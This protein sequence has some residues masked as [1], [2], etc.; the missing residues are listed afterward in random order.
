MDGVFG[1]GKPYTVGIEEEFQLV[2]PGSRGLVPAVERVIAAGNGT[3]LVTSELSRSCVE[4]VSPVYET[5]SDLA[6]ELPGLRREVAEMAR[7]GGAEIVAAGT[8]PFSEP[9]EQP[10]AIQVRAERVARAA[11]AIPDWPTRQRRGDSP[12]HTWAPSAPAATVSQAI[13][14]PV[15]QAQA[16]Q[17]ARAAEA[18]PDW[19]TRQRRSS[20]VSGNQ[21]G[22][23]GEIVRAGMT[24]SQTVQPPRNQKG[25]IKSTPPKTHDQRRPNCQRIRNPAEYRDTTGCPPRNG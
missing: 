1:A 6:R 4:M 7:K 10:L 13:Q 9:T 15:V 25:Y 22:T 19:P 5:V 17:A 11:E 23:V 2:E 14:R 20:P 12:R 24:T 3:S 16:E 18:I 21:V 8:H